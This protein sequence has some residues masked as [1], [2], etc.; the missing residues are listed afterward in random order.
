VEKD[1][2]LAAAIEGMSKG[3]M[4]RIDFPMRRVKCE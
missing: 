2:S 1:G 4:K 3:K